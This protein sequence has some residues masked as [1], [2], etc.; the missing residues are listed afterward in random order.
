[1]H[2]IKSC[3]AILFLLLLCGCE[4]VTREK[5]SFMSPGN[6]GIALR[7]EAKARLL[8]SGEQQLS[9]AIE[10]S[11]ASAFNKKGG[12]GLKIVLGPSAAL[13]YYIIVNVTTGHKESQYSSTR[14][15]SI[16]RVVERDGERN[17]R[18]VVE[19]VPGR[20]DASG[21]MYAAVAIYSV[22]SL[23]P[24]HYFEFSANDG[25]IDNGGVGQHSREAFT[26]KFVAEISMKFSDMISSQWRRFS[27]AIPKDDVDIEMVNALKKGAFEAVEARGRTLMPGSFDEYVQKVKSSKNAKKYNA[28]LCCYYLLALSKEAR[29]FDIDNLRSLYRQYYQIL[30]LTENEGLAE[31]CANSLARIEK[32]A[33]MT[34]NKI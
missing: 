21:A 12:N 29:H 23:E 17:G 26:N 20:T 6:G 13:D 24:V 14:F 10:E 33:L 9:R 25:V 16:T 22:T 1:M 5:L 19:T 34:G 11:I 2:R 8:V 30:M 31:A 7:Q 4:N 3:L 32:K 15:N 27:T 18:D 28:G